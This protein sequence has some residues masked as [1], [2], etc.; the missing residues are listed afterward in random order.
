MAVPQG[1][2]TFSPSPAKATNFMQ[3]V[4]GLLIA[5]GL[6]GW[7][8]RQPASAEE[9]PSKPITIMVGLAAGG[10]TDVTARLYAEV[11]SRNVGQRI[12]IENRPA[13][14]GAVAA[15]SVQNAPADGYTLLV[16]SG[17]Q[18]ATVAAMGS[19][20]YD[21]V[22]GF[23]FVTLLFN[24]VVAVVVP[25]D[26]P[27]TTLA[28]LFDIGRAR[29]GGLAMGTP[30]LGSPA[31]LLGARLAL[32]GNVPVQAVHYRGGA[33]MMTDVLTGRV[34]FAVV[35]LS[36]S[37]TFLAEKKLRALAVD[38]EQRW[39]ALPEVPTLAALGYGK[40]K[41]ANWFGLAAPPAMSA[42][43]VGRLNAEF[44]KAS[45]DGDLIRRLAENGTPIVT[46]TPD[47]MHELMVHETAA[48]VDLVKILGIRAQ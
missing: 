20:P 5:L 2:A 3:S 16:F 48:M 27:A 46:S 10:I 15:A 29:P 28:Q 25:P 19:A 43:L 8:Y 38:A 1:A 47:E 41:V 34:D 44:I 4:T 36:T 7:S 18:H 22:Q 11:V 30:G 31:H 23:T 42:A 40:E 26:S 45:R 9:F 33:P 6:I 12:N 24:S 32:A 13:A 21:P 14:G 17:S 35:T 37:R 39:P